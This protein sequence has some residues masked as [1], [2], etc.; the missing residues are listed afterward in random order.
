VLEEKLMKDAKR[1][2]VSVELL[3]E[4]ARNLNLLDRCAKSVYARP[5]TSNK[6][7]KLEMQ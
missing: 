2:G 7:M 3:K 5:K 6:A 1:R 4:T